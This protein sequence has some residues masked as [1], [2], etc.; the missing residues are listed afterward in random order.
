MTT[1]S[2]LYVYVPTSHLD[3]VKDAMFE[4]GAG[5]YEDYSHCCTQ[6]KVEGQFKPLANAQPH[7]GQINTLTQVEEYKVEMVCAPEHVEHVVAA[8][9][10]AHPYERPA[11]GTW[12]IEQYD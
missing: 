5:R 11:Y 10:N 6:V 3:A 7:I 12:N 2:Q 4:A 8:L 1:L 9:I